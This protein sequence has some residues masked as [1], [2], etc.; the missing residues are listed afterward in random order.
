MRTFTARG[1]IVLSVIGPAAHSERGEMKSL[2]EELSDGGCGYDQVRMSGFDSG[3][4]ASHKKGN[5]QILLMTSSTLLVLH[6]RSKIKSI[7][8]ISNTAERAG[9]PVS[10]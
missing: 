3:S 8:V 1:D 4:A 6:S 7:S 9:V 5:K 2:Y 10:L